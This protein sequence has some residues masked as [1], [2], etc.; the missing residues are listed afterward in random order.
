MPPLFDLLTVVSTMAYPTANLIVLGFYGYAAVYSRFRLPFTLL[1]IAIC[2]LLLRQL[3]EVLLT[4]QK[5]SGIA[6]ISKP[7][8]RVL[9]PI[10]AASDYVSLALYI[11]GAMFLVRSILKQPSNPND[12]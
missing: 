3:S 6:I 8:A 10:T 2:F 11:T 4:V 9:W 7:V 12:G 1:A 5:L